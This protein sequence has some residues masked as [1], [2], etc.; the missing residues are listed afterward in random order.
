MG[1]VVREVN[2]ELFEFVAKYVYETYH[3]LVSME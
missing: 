2:N 3:Y 1:N